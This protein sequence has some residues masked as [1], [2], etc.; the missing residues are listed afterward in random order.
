M[1]NAPC[2]DLIISIINLGPAKCILN[3]SPQIAK[4]VTEIVPI[5]TM[6]LIIKLI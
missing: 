3:Q 1:A 2:D 5:A 6:Q 4:I